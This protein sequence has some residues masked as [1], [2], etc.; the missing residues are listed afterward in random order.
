MRDRFPSRTK[1]HFFNSFFIERLLR[2]DKKYRYANVS[3]W[4]NKLQ[5]IFD[6]DKI[7]FP[8]NTGNIHWTLACVYIK[9]KEIHYFDSMAQM[10][11]LGSFYMNG[12][13]RW[14][15]DEGEKMN[16]TVNK[17]EWTL[18]DHLDEFPQQDNDYDCG[19]FAIACAD[20]LLDDLPVT[21]LFSAFSI[22]N[23][24]FWREKVAVDILRG[25]LTY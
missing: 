9:K 10:M 12:L 11:K 21:G 16:V 2:T 8:I 6:L 25:K 17:E 14:I 5:S 15:Q 22:A 13:L 24:P 1:S 20:H 23:M 4:T 7:V 19:M 18:I 3:R